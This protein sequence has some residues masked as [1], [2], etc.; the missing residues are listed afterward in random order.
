MKNKA[1]PL[2]ILVILVI[3]VIITMVMKNLSYSGVTLSSTLTTNDFANLGLS[4]QVPDDWVLHEIVGSPANKEGISDNFIIHGGRL[5]GALPWIKI[6]QF[7]NTFNNKS[8]EIEKL[9]NSDVLR[10]NEEYDIQSLNIKGFDNYSIISFVY[11]KDGDLYEKAGRL[12]TCKDWIGENDSYL[13]IVSICA[14]DEQWKVVEPIYNQIVT[15][16]K[17]YE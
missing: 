4:L 5:A 15:S 6:Y 12:I 17:S 7:E 9:V 2:K 1:I 14:T 13:Y 3:G 8:E 16:I 11:S 10:V